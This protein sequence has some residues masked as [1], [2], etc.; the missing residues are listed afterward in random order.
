MNCIHI[1][2][3][4]NQTQYEVTPTSTGIKHVLCLSCFEIYK[5]DPR[6]SPIES[7]GYNIYRSSDASLPKNQWTK[8]NDKP[9]PRTA[10]K[11]QF[12]LGKVPEGGS[13]YITAINAIGLESVPSEV[14][15]IPGEDAPK[16][17]VKSVLIFGE[18]T[19]E[20]KIVEAVTLPWFDILELLKNDPNAAFQIPG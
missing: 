14:L 20:G 1:A 16:L 5:H 15:D 18:T 7:E 4:P 19:D 2:K 10:N 17:V 9:I 13:F 8:V 12:N 11:M 3:N 6:K